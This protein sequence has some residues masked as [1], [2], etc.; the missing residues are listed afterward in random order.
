MSKSKNALVKLKI[1]KARTTIMLPASTLEAMRAVREVEYVLQSYQI[2]LAL[3]E[4]MK[5]YQ[6]LLDKR[7]IK[8]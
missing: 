7:G 3:I 1:P 4:Y 5:K 6:T 2:E 8:I